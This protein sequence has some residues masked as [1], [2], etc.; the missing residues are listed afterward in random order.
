[1]AG[2]KF[3]RALAPDVWEGVR[4]VKPPARGA[5]NPRLPARVAQAGTGPGDMHRT[6]SLTPI[7]AAAAL[8]LLLAGCRDSAELPEQAT[9][10]PHPALPAPKERLIPTLNIAKATGWKQGEMPGAANG[11]TVSAYATGLDHPRWLYV[12]PNGD[13]LVAETNTPKQEEPA[14][15]GG[16]MGWIRGEV[17]GWAMQ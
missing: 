8:V 15:A 17:M 5:C 9:Q 10:G 14:G 4:K 6:I 13:V 16:V 12:L 2:R 3:P 7:A 11:L 1:M